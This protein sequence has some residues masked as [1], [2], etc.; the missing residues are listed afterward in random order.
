MFGAEM[1]QAQLA[2]AV[3]RA[4]VP[5]S[6]F[7]L[8]RIE[9]DQRRPTLPELLGMAQVLGVTLSD[10]GVTAAEYPEIKFLKEPE[11]RALLEATPS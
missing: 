5:L 1:T 4:G 11:T 6:R 3:T 10:L 2:H 9:T 8:N 7:M